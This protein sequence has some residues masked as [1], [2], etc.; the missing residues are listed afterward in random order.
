MLD[1]LDDEAQRVWLRIRWAVSVINDDVLTLPRLSKLDLSL[2]FLI[3]TLSM[4]CEIVGAGLLVC[5]I[6]ATAHRAAITRSMP[7]AL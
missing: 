7:E 5:Q 3:P 4:L 6:R 1:W 2:E